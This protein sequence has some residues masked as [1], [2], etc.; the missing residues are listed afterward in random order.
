LRA[1]ETKERQPRRRIQCTCGTV[2][3]AG[4]HTPQICPTCR[5]PLV[6]T[7]E[8]VADA[9]PLRPAALPGTPGRQAG[10][11]V[12]IVPRGQ[13]DMILAPEARPAGLLHSPLF[14]IALAALLI[15]GII[16]A[17]GFGLLVWLNS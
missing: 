12:N 3:L 16:A 9:P 13:G 11:G 17:A 5:R 8:T 10:S 6:V 14:W 7:E 2:V 4:K 15:G 1:P